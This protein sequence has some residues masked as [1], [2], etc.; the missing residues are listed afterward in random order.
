LGEERLPLEIQ[1]LYTELMEQLAS[2]ARFPGDILLAWDDDKQR[3]E[4]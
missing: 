3:G 1:A 2:F 4:S